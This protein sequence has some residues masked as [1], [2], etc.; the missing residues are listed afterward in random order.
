M[1]ST[2][3]RPI[4]VLRIIAR[5]NVGGPAWQVSVLTRGLSRERFESRVIVG[6]VGEGEGDFIELRD[7]DLPVVKIPVLGRAL[8]IGDDLRAFGASRQAIRDY[9]PDIVHTHTT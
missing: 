6:D 2:E 8:R 7:P 4:R 1:N 5:M 9:Q 3:G